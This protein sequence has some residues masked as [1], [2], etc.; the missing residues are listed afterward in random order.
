VYLEPLENLKNKGGDQNPLKKTEHNQTKVA[1]A[2]S[3]MKKTMTIFGL[4][5]IASVILTS[6]SNASNDTKEISNKDENSKSIPDTLK[7]NAKNESESEVIEPTNITCKLFFETGDNENEET[8]EISKGKVYER[9]DFRTKKTYTFCPE[10]ETFHH[11]TLLGTGNNLSFTV[12][13][14]NKQIFKRDN[15]DLKDKLTFTSKDFKIT[16]GESAKYLITIT[17]NQIEI[18]KGKIDYRGCM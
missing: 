9:D 1:T 17:Q 7:A 15:I 18:F 11:I 16:D 5:F 12:N 4:M 14:D 8:G 13:A 2:R 10:I 3:K 6:C